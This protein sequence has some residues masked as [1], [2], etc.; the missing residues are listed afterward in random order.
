MEDV[1]AR[2]ERCKIQPPPA[3]QTNTAEQ[4]QY[5]TGLVFSMRPQFCDANREFG[6]R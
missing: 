4:T 1:L 2:H 5:D 6:I 3:M